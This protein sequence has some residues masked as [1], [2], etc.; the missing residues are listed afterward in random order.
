M[1]T[2]HDDEEDEFGFV[3]TI[4]LL[5]S[6]GELSVPIYSNLFSACL[7]SVKFYGPCSLVTLD[8]ILLE[9][10]RIHT[11]HPNEEGSR[12]LQQVAGPRKLVPALH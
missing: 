4:C 9:V 6:L 5:E 2:E 1:A 7:A 8:H 11:V 12:V 3:S 10:C